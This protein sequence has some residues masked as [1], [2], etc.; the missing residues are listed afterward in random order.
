MCA[1]RTT[2]RTARGVPHTHTQRHCVRER[3]Q[4]AHDA[5][6]QHRGINTGETT[7][8]RMPMDC[9]PQHTRAC[10]SP[11]SVFCRNFRRKKRKLPNALSVWARPRLF[12][13]RPFPPNNAGG[14]LLFLDREVHLPLAVC[15]RAFLLLPITFQLASLLF[16]LSLVPV[17]PLGRTRFL[18]SINFLRGVCLCAPL[19]LRPLSDCAPPIQLCWCS[20]SWAFVVVFHCPRVRNQHNFPFS[21]LDFLLCASYFDPVY[22]T[23]PRCVFD[24]RM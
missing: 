18:V 20:F 23:L 21:A 19:Y 7:H 1:H 14:C 12:I 11:F 15:I 6:T 10:A 17:F 8:A 22:L 9:T 5:R 24:S 4:G 13:S 2:H 3:D 16:T